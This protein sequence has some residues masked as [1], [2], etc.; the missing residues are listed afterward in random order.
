M[1][2]CVCVCV[3]VWE[4]WGECRQHLGVRTSLS[5]VIPAGLSLE[6]GC[7]APVHFADT[8]GLDGRCP[9]K[10]SPVW[11][12]IH[13]AIHVELGDKASGRSRS[14]ST[15]GRGRAWTA[16]ESGWVESWKPW[17]SLHYH[18][19]YCYSPFQA[20]GTVL[21]RNKYAEMILKEADSEILITAWK[22]FLDTST[23]S[24][25]PLAPT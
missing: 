21:V 9:L 11:Q 13:R 5:Y 22:R 7:C 25:S 4:D 1:C 6:C 10:G 24:P 18:H 8:S 3:C 12:H 14:G 16:A 23:I 2:V 19:H 15:G 17:K 20:V